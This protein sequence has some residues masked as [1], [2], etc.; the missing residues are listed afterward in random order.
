[1]GEHIG[2]PAGDLINGMDTG[3]EGSHRHLRSEDQRPRDWK[4]ELRPWRRVSYPSEHGGR[5]V[6][7]ARVVGR[8][9]M[10]GHRSCRPWM[11]ASTAARRR[12]GRTEK[13]LGK[14]RRRRTYAATIRA[15]RRSRGGARRE[16]TTRP[17]DEKRTTGASSATVSGEECGFADFV[18]V[19]CGVCIPQGEIFQGEHCSLCAVVNR[20][21]DTWCETGNSG[22]EMSSVGKVS[23]VEENDGSRP[24]HYGHRR[25]GE[26]QNPGPPV[27]TETPIG[28]TV[29]S[30][31]QRNAEDKLPWSE[32]RPQDRL[33]YPRPHRPGFR[34][35]WTPGFADGTG[36][37]AEEGE[38]AEVFQL[39]I[40]TVNA[41]SWGPLRK[42]LRA[43]AAHIVFAQET[44][45]AESKH[46]EISKW[47]IGNG[48]KMV[49]APAV[50]GKRG[51]CGRGGYFRA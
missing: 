5:V 35:V 39:V 26:A 27:E 10:Q 29:S 3:D 42:R 49:A 23:N 38:A 22:G 43:T 21:E 20:G 47:A 9:R 41:T 11:R 6:V 15:D 37:S 1:M 4:I 36:P 28:A 24:S 46:A 51:C 50:G 45:V 34:D 7:A 2:R 33:A 18:D 48:W 12:G 31:G 17:H 40:E 32:A 8:R 14:D 16:C 25:T 13:P 19:R 44:K 30:E